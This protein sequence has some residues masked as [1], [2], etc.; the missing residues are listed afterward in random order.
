MTQSQQASPD[1]LPPCSTQMPWAYL[2]MCYCAK[3]CNPEQSKTDSKTDHSVQDSCLL[4]SS[5]L[6]M[7]HL[8]QLSLPTAPPS[9]SVQSDLHYTTAVSGC[10]FSPDDQDMAVSHSPTSLLCCQQTV[11]G[12]CLLCLGPVKVHRNLMEEIRK[13]K[14][15]V[16]SLTIIHFLV[17]YCILTFLCCMKA[18]S[19]NGRLYI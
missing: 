4:F 6:C 11:R 8:Y 19:P 10:R 13:Y 18:T 9:N 2:L 3:Q 1:T 5:F 7:S 17:Y 16:I 12:F 14:Q 15:F